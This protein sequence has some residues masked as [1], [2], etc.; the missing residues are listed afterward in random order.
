MASLRISVVQYLNT[1]PLVY[2]FTRGPL[3][4]KYDLSFTVP[5]ECAEALRSGAADVAII[6]AIEYQRI[7]NLVVLPDLSIASKERVRSLLIVSKLP[8][9]EVQ[10]L[11]L[12]RSSRS[13]QTLTRILCEDRWNIAPQFTQA[14]PDLAQMLQGS[15]AA[16]VIG[17]PALRIA[18]QA[19]QCVKPGADGEWVCSGSLVGLPQTPNLHLYDVV[20]E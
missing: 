14:T 3:Q 10:S 5:S 2:G 12:D 15:D 13:T 20:H 6:P 11:A 8:I 1:A 9:R 19:E 18:I 4:G 7:P 17:D 16:L